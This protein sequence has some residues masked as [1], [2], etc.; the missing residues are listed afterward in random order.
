MIPDLED[1][2]VLPPGLH[3]T[4]WPEFC[5]RFGWTQHRQR[6]INGLRRALQALKAAGCVAVYVDGSFVTAKQVPNDYDACWDV[7]GVDGSQL[8][9]V[10]LAGGYPPGMIRGAGSSP[11]RLSH[12]KT[13]AARVHPE[14]LRSP[15]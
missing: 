9:P 6:L 13:A 15:R 7:S 1:T 3:G 4:T 11:T 14:V 10:F 12:P 5:K 2:G 8:D